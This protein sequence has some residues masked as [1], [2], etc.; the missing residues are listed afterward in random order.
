[1]KIVL[2]TKT[3]KIRIYATEEQS[4]KFQEL[5]MAYRDAENFISQYIFDHDCDTNFYRVC[6]E[7]YYQIRG[8]FGLKAQISQACVKEVISRYSTVDTQLRQKP[9]HYRE[10]GKTYKVKRDS[11]W[12]LKPLKFKGLTATLVINKDWSFTKGKISLLTMGKRE[13]CDYDHKIVEKF[14]QEGYVLGSGK[15]VCR[16]KGKKLLWFLHIAVTREIPDFDRK[17]PSA[18]VGID[19]GLRFLITVYDG[20]KTT[21][22]SG[23]P[24]AKK[25]AHY[26]KLRARL[27]SKGTK[28]A[29]RLLKKLAGRE[30]RWMTDINHQLSKALV[31]EYGAN[32]VF[33]LEDLT[34]VSFD[35]R[36]LKRTKEG[37]NELR[38]WT[39]YQFEQ[40]L[41]YKAEAVGAK[42][43]KV[44]AK[45]TS[46]RCPYCG[47]IDKSQR[48]H[49]HHEYRCTCGCRMNDDRVAA[50]NLQELG[51]R[52]ISGE[53]DPK[54]LKE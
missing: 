40:F 38:S 39:F 5:T 31:T 18:V 11:S 29:K 45:Y 33:V 35:E 8:N 3:L 14:L 7:V 4:K 48:D 28:S 46:Q 51:R 34:G 16:R 1:V 52:F 50:I 20:K 43:L 49:D 47:K 41:Q 10:N 32:A 22:V 9:F 25:R 53:D 26:A 44:S 19:Q 42:F 36:N 15:L 13:L 17:N 23:K 37:R 30:T 24:I 2:Q 54:I 21:F 12:L 27:Q 6:K